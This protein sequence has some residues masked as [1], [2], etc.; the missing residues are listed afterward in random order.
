MWGLSDEASVFSIVAYMD[1][2]L[3]ACVSYH[4]YFVEGNLEEQLK[5]SVI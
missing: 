5:K 1:R 3:D 2:S 4:T